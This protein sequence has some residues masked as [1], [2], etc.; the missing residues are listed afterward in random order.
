MKFKNYFQFFFLFITMLIISNSIFAQDDYKYKYLEL[1]RAGK[2]DDLKTLL[3]KWEKAEPKNPEMF[4]GYFNYY[5][6]RNK[7]EQAVMGQMQDGRYGMFN[8]IIYNSND[9]KAGIGYLDKGLKYVPNRLDIHYGKIDAFFAIKDYESAGKTLYNLIAISP[10]YNAT[11]MLEDNKS[12]E[13]G[14]K[15]L[16][17]YISQY[18]DKFFWVGTN[19]ALE[20][21]ITCSECEIKTYPEN[22]RGYNILATAYIEAGDPEKAIKYL[23]DAEK[24][25]NTDCIILINI[26]IVY[27]K[28]KNIDKAKEYFNKAIK[29]GNDVEKNQAQYYLDSL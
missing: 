20:Q 18:F 2:Y 13:D 23:L 27:G 10:K 21:A 12:V 1:L 15:Y 17:G 3:V 16:L 4:I 28:L 9:V 26:G 7:T 22:T 8:D 24:V 5:A 11:W 29:I 6:N 14:Q 25:D 19:V